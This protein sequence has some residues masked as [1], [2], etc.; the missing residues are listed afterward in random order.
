MYRPLVVGAEGARAPRAS[1]LVECTYQGELYSYTL[2]SE[3]TN[4]Q[5]KNVN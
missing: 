3:G 4:F 1:L 5:V 2:I